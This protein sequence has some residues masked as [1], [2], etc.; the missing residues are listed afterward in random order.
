MSPARTIAKAQQH[1]VT[2]IYP[3][4]GGVYPDHHK[5]ESNTVP[6]VTVPAAFRRATTVASCAAGVRPMNFVPTV[7][8]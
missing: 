7:V 5:T 1:A 3:L 6:I 4:P 2:R 8:G